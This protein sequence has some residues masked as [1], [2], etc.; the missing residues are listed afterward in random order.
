ML[1]RKPIRWR[2]CAAG[3][4]LEQIRRRSRGLRGEGPLSRL[5]P[6]IEQ[7]ER[8][9]DHRRICR[10]RR[11]GVAAGVL[12]QRTQRLLGEIPA[13]ASDIERIIR[14]QDRAAPSSH[15]LV[16][17]L[18]QL[19]SEFDGVR[20]K[21][22]AVCALTDPI[23]LDDVD[24]GPFE[25]QLPFDVLADPTSSGD[26]RVIATEPITWPIS[27]VPRLPEACAR[28]RANGTPRSSR[29]FVSLLRH[30][31]SRPGMTSPHASCKGI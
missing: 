21:S 29:S 14:R 9:M 15:D 11:W 17:E 25:I 28:K 1:D 19:E 10:Q 8:I 13:I 20:Y 3:R 23:H 4:I 2:C 16:G 6:R 18:E 26:Y 7:L 22:C 27:T 12:S 5:A 30:A 24:L 31:Q